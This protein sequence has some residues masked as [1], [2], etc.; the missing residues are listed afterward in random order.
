MNRAKDLADVR[1]QLAGA[2][3]SEGLSELIRAA[4]E[5]TR[6]QLRDQDPLF[7]AIV[8]AEPTLIRLSE[9]MHSGTRPV[10]PAGLGLGC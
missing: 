9:L 1:A 7:A 5:L 3:V 4:E 10:S 2:H 8:E 6:A